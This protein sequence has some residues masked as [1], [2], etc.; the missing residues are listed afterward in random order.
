MLCFIFFFSWELKTVIF[1]CICRFCAPP[2]PPLIMESLL[3][4]TL[5]AKQGCLTDPWIRNLWLSFLKKN[6]PCLDVWDHR[7]NPASEK[8][9]RE[10]A[11]S[12]FKG[13]W[14]WTCVEGA[15]DPFF[16]RTHRSCGWMCIISIIVGVSPARLEAPQRQG[17]PD[18][19]LFPIPEVWH[20]GGCLYSPRSSLCSCLVVVLVQTTSLWVFPHL[21]N[22]RVS[23]VLCF[24]LPLSLDPV[25]SYSYIEAG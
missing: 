21:K 11:G 13:L 18:L 24:Y 20:C 14:L 6:Q 19:H 3:A 7:D 5:I 15:L 9:P 17:L 4:P 8:N 22:T 23:W 2:W 12:W 1:W 10:G 16:F 25:C